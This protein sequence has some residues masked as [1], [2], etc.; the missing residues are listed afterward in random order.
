MGH[1]DLCF[2][3]EEQLEKEWRGD[4]DKEEWEKVLKE[5]KG[6]VKRRRSRLEMWIRMVFGNEHYVLS[7]CFSNNIRMIFR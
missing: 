1:L 5:V 3:G 4:M 7:E 2:R 6:E